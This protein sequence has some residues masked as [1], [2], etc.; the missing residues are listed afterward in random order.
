MT[1]LED[2]LSL[3]SYEQSNDAAMSPDTSKQTYEL[4]PLGYEKSNDL[5]VPPEAF[6]QMDEL[7]K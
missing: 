6:E 2:R 5:A 7:L 1:G 3:S 4:P